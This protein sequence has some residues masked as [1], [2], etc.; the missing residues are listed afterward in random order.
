[1]VQVRS[2]FV[3]LHPNSVLPNS[4][5]EQLVDVIAARLFG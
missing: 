4:R 2:I 5:S 1:M 3:A